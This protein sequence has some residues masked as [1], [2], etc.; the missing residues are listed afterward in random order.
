MQIVD[1][2]AD[3]L[4]T[5]DIRADLKTM[6]EE[7]EQLLRKIEKNRKRVARMPQLEKHLEFAGKFHTANERAQE[8]QLQLQ[9]QRNAV[10]KVAQQPHSN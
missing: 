9:E 1:A 7:R 6:A 2:R 5:E 3:Y 4:R 10:R 8:L